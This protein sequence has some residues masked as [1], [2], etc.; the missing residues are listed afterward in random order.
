MRMLFTWCAR[1]QVQ[2]KTKHVFRLFCYFCECNF[3]EFFFLAFT[4]SYWCLFPFCLTC[5]MP[6]IHKE[7]GIF[8]PDFSVL[9]MLLAFSRKKVR[10]DV[11]TKKHNCLKTVSFYVSPWTCSLSGFLSPLTI[12]FFFSFSSFYEVSLQCSRPFS[13]ASVSGSA[14]CK[15]QNDGSVQKGC[16]GGK[17][18]RDWNILADKKEKSK[19]LKEWEGTFPI[20]S[21]TVLWN[22]SQPCTFSR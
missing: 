18:E 14:V 8:L 1:W 5:V 7:V 10:A 17:A 22:E 12:N 11:K 2:V 9:Y 20:Q 19:G 16:G 15:C 21:A 6:W 4:G 13:S 3:Y